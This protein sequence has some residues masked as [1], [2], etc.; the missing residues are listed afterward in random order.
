MSNKKDLLERI[1]KECKGL[2]SLGNKFDLG[3]LLNPVPP[4]PTSWYGI[5]RDNTI[6]SPDWTRIAS[7]PEDMALHASLPV[8]ALF[9]PCVM[10]PD[11]TVNYY[12]K[13][14]DFS[15]KIDGVTASNIDGTDGNVMSHQSASYWKLTEIEGTVERIKIS[16][17]PQ[18]E[19]GWV[20][21]TPQYYSCYEGQVVGGKLN[22][23]S[24]VLATTNVNETNFRAYARANGAGHEQQWIRPY[25][26]LIHLFMVQFAT[27][28]TQKPVNM[29]L[30]VDGY[31]QGG[32][33]AGVTTANGVEW[34]AFNGYTP[35][36][37]NGSCNSMPKHWGEVSVIVPDF[38]GAGVNRTFTVPRFLYVENIFGHIWK[39]VDG[40]TINHLADRREAYV[41]DN[42]AQFVDSSSVNGRLAG[43]LPLNIANGHFTKVLFPEILPT[44]PAGGDQNTYYCDRVYQSA[45][46]S[47][48]RALV[49]GGSA[50]HDVFAGAFS[51]NANYGSSITNALIGA[52]LHVK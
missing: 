7:S 34:N 40:V 27:N 14:D 39:W 17:Y 36:I 6:A 20:E 43:L 48:W 5:E 44:D 51:A 29:T 28:N 25:T 50:A 16:P 26:E 24:G 19:A 18:T 31:S 8:H 49:S 47:G 12:L 32:L 23:V 21:I 33:G 41:F 4:A 9:K 11:K 46:N 15:L 38:G 30:T 35:F 45:L 22:S 10:N 3:S 2:N 13:P 1:L 37:T 52:R 42:P